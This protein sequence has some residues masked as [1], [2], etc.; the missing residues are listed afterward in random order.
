MV[1][2]SGLRVSSA[3]EVYSEHNMQLVYQ[4][5]LEI[6]LSPH[7]FPRDSCFK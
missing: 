3:G 5:Y 1:W 7:V 6:L 4:D 2:S